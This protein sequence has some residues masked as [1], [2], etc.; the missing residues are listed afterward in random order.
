MVITNH[1][2]LKAEDSSFWEGLF[3]VN[4]IVVFMQCADSVVANGELIVIHAFLIDLNL[5]GGYF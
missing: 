1:F 4:L 3:A 5:Q 2:Y